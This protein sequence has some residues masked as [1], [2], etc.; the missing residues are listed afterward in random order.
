MQQQAG[1]G[2]KDY[3][4]AEGLKKYVRTLTCGSGRAACGCPCPTPP[5][6][7]SVGKARVGNERRETRVG[8]VWSTGCGLRRLQEWEMRDKRQE[9]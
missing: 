7:P 5:V 3:V 9:W 2:S 8:N 6:R 1:R 4:R